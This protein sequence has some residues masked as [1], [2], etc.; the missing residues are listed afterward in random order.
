MD[1]LRGLAELQVPDLVARSP[2]IRATARCDRNS[3]ER[4]YEIGDSAA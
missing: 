2:S 4:S 1:M 3:A